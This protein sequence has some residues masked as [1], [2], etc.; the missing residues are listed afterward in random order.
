[1]SEVRER[2]V[3]YAITHIGNLKNGTNEPIYKIEITGR[4][5]GQ[6]GTN[7]ET[8]TD[9]HTFSHVSS[10]LELPIYRLVTDNLHPER[11]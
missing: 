9:I 7:W 6:G 10:Q 4:K 11:S 3:S 5:A 8:G 2:Q 1:M